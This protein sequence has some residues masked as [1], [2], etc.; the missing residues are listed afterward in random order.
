MIK[1]QLQNNDTQYS[2]VKQREIYT[3]QPVITKAQF[4]SYKL[5]YKIKDLSQAYINIYKI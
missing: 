2:N 3:I 5:I 1:L 4:A